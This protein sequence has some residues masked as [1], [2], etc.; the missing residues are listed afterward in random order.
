[1]GGVMTL[2][3][4]L[5][6]GNARFVEETWDAAEAELAVAPAKRLAVLAC[7]DCRYHVGR[8]L[9]LEHGDAKVIRNA[10]NHLDDGAVRSLTVAIHALGVERVVVLGHTDC[11]MTTLTDP[12][13]PLVASVRER[14]EVPDETALSAEFL[15]WVGPFA[16][17]RQHVQAVMAAVLQHP[18]VPP[19]IEVYGMI[20]DND[21]GKV[22]VVAP[23]AP[24]EGAA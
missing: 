14:T 23:V 15:E 13:N 9:G 19:G 21:S 17:P 4:D 16:E 2:M 11:G 1:M 20:Y 6:A 12:Q 22:D 7:M 18:L 3:D 10:G 5:L 8:V 24:A